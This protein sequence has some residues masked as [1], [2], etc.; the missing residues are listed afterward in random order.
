MFRK[1]HLSLLALAAVVAAG[2]FFS[3]ARAEEDKDA[4]L[5]NGKDLTGWRVYITDKDKSKAK[6]TDVWKVEDGELQ[7]K[8]TPFGYI[9]TEKEYSNYVLELEWKWPAKAGNSGVLLHVSGADAIWPKSWEAQ[10]FSG[11][12]G[13]IWLIGGFKLAVDKERQ[14]PKQARHFFR[15][16]TDKPVE[17]KPGGWNKYRITCKGDSVKLEINGKVVNEGTDSELTKGK[18]ALQ[19]EGA[20]IHFRNIKLTPIK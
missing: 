4:A 7:T 10:L 6:P 13:D 2:S 14:D 9:I 12:A 11:S 5:F 19:A 18:I 17:V 3:L 20:P 15:I 8:G 16:K 1:S